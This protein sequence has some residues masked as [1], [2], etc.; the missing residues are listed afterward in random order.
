MSFYKNF[1]IC[2]LGV[3]ITSLATAFFISSV[4]AILIGTEVVVNQSDQNFKLYAALPEEGLQSSDEIVRTDIRASLIKKFF[5]KHN[6]DLANSSEAVLDT[7]VRFN[8]DY[9]TVS[10]V[11]LIQDTPSSNQAILQLG[12]NLK[13]YADEGLKTPDQIVTKYIP[14]SKTEAK[15]W[16]R[17]VASYLTQF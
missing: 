1:K 13:N 3:Y 2:L 15:V 9:K 17:K 5:K 14:D 10:A 16:S 4:A 8:L 6:S 11:A 7:A 12:Q